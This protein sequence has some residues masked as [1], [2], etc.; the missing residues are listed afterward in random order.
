MTRP[1][2]LSEYH[3]AFREQ[4]K[5]LVERK[6]HGGTTK[7]TEEVDERPEGPTVDLMDAL[8]R[9]LHTSGST[10]RSDHV[11][12]VAL[13]SPSKHPRGKVRAKAH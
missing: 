7:A 3:D 10:R 5:K 4:V 12:H 1:L 13:R 9:S 2:D 6:K 11:R 8:R